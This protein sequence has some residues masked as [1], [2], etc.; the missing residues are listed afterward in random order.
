MN[1]EGI[2]KDLEEVRG[3]TVVWSWH[4][5]PMAVRLKRTIG[6]LGDYH[7]GSSIAVVVQGDCER[8]FGLVA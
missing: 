2:L 3:L 7:G 5:E 1:E 8:G 4:S 6:V